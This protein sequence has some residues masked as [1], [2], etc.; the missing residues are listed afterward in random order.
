MAYTGLARQIEAAADRI[1]KEVNDATKMQS[2]FQFQ[3]AAPTLGTITAEH[4]D[5]SFTVTFADN[6]VNTSC[7]STYRVVRVTDKV[8]VIGSQIQ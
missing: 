3:S 7:F 8:N 5:G 1:F 2:S 4:A 6:S